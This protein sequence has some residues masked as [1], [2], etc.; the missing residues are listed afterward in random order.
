M[1]ES[2]ENGPFE[3]YYKNGEI[4]WKGTFIDGPNEVGL[5]TEYSEEG[6]ILKKM[7][8]SKYSDDYICQTIWEKGKGEV[9]LKLKY[10]E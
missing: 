1:R 3:E 7:E 8:C 4:H 2:T 5:L 6:E 9:K 10:E